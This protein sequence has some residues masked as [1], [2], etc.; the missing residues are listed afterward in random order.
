M[1]G[2]LWNVRG[3]EK[4]GRQQRI[5]DLCRQYQLSFIGVQETKNKISAKVT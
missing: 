3:L 1:K 4:K 2:I 5:S